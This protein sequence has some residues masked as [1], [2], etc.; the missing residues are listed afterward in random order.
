MTRNSFANNI[1]WAEMH[2]PQT[3]LLKKGK[4]DWW[5]IRGYYNSK[6]ASGIQ[7]RFQATPV[8][9]AA[10]FIHPPSP[11][12]KI[13]INTDKAEDASIA[14]YRNQTHQFIFCM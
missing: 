7:T 1:N 2:L 12:L 11:A 3:F 14:L 10:P 9:Q 4:V 6:V 13:A 5:H 8:C